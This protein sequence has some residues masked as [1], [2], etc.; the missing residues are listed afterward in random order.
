MHG[1]NAYSLATVVCEHDGKG[2]DHAMLGGIWRKSYAQ[3]L[4]LDSRPLKSRVDVYDPQNSG[5]R[6]LKLLSGAGIKAGAQCQ[7]HAKRVAQTHPGAARDTFE[8][9]VSS[10]H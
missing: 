9:Q 7:A 5:K 6:Y 4:R 8:V 10:G 1:S 2:D 3:M